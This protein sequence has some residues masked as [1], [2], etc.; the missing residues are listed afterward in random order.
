MFIISIVNINKAL[1]VKTYIDLKK[2][3]SSHFYAYLS[4]FD[5]KVSKTLSPLRE[6]RVDYRIELKKD[7]ESQE[8]EVPWGS[9]Y[10][11]SWDELLILRKTLSELLDKGFIK[12]NNSLMIALILF[13]KKLKN[14]L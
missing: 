2:K 8:P 11:M 5:R 3:L 14:K 9:L 7:K 12:V 1:Y 13:I 10:N 4:I 6:L